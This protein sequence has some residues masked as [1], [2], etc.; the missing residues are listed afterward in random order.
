MDLA[1]L[2]QGYGY[3]VIFAGTFVEG[4]TI[5]ALG[6]YFAHQGY[7]QLW[8]VVLVAFVGA[9]CGDQLFFWLGRH[10]AKRLLERFPKMRD[11]VGT[12]LTKIEQHQIKVMLSMR[13]LWGMR[14][15]LPVALGLSSIRGVRFLWFN[16]LSAAIWSIAFTYVGYGASHVFSQVVEDIRRF[17][18]W[19]A[20]ALVLLALIALAWHLGKP[21]RSIDGGDA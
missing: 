6:G 4:E 15:A 9:V 18:W 5:L 20:G 16:L 12:A 11:K 8:L 7:L 10:H 19:I 14:I 1:A 17:E 2:L 21:R 13:F 3:L